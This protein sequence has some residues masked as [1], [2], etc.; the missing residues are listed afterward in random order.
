M[1]LSDQDITAA[2]DDGSINDHSNRWHELMGVRAA[3][4]S[5]RGAKTVRRMRRRSRIT[6]HQER[7]V[8]P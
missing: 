2:I 6:K 8:Q 4:L 1:I 5:V 7:I 3:L